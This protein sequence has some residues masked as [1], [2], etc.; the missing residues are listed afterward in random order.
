M[1]H[2][3]GVKTSQTHKHKCCHEHA[4]KAAPDKTS[5]NVPCKQCGDKNC[6]CL[7]GTCGA[8]SIL[9]S[10]GINLSSP[11][12]AANQFGILNE[13]VASNHDGRLKRPPKV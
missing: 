3:D 12:V 2:E 8:A 7:G 6:K 5:Q 4:G 11:I 9:G 1:S 13:T 10:Q